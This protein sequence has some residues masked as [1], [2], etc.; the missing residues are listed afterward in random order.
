[1]SA[2][3]LVVESTGEMQQQEPSVEAPV[4]DVH[5]PPPMA[6]SSPM[7]MNT[8]DQG[9][10][11]REPETGI[12]EGEPG[13][14]MDDSNAEAEEV[15]VVAAG[16]RAEGQALEEGEMGEEDEEEEVEEELK[17]VV[18]VGGKCYMDMEKDGTKDQ[19]RW[20]LGITQACNIC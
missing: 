13:E 12:M 6:E 19:K 3:D 11:A 4:P 14:I 18:E 20:E 7:V 15:G 10:E 1:M 16:G 2:E 5:P 17:N 8:S 9:S